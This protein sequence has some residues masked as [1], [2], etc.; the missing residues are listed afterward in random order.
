MHIEGLERIIVREWIRI[1]NDVGFP[2]PLGEGDCRGG[3][4]FEFDEPHLDSPIVALAQ[5]AGLPTRMLDFTSDPRIAAFFAAE[6]VRGR[7]DSI[8]VWAFRRDSIMIGSPIRVHEFPRADNS[9]L[10]A[11]RGVLLGL[12]SELLRTLLDEMM[13][14]PSIDELASGPRVKVTT[15]SSVCDDVLE[16]LEA[17]RI[18]RAHLFPHHASVTDAFWATTHRLQRQAN[19]AA[20]P[21][22]A[23]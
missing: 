8:A 13:R 1:T 14:I 21:S 16:H 6:T 5:H 17:A 7:G 23:R 4:P 11:Q 12:E 22:D 15:P 2:I 20:R 19:A 18:T 10:G 9:L 3:L